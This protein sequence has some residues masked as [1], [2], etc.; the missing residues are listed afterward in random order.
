MGLAVEQKRGINTKGKYKGQCCGNPNTGGDTSIDPK[1]DNMDDEK[2][3]IDNSAHAIY[4]KG[5]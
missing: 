2:G 1:I 5:K 4:R 3:F